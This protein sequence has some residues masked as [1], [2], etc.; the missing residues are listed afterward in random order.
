MKYV[1]SIKMYITLKNT[2]SHDVYVVL[3]N[4]I[5][6]ILHCLFNPEEK[7]WMLRILVID[8]KTNFKISIYIDGIIVAE[9]YD[10]GG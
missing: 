10:T 7:M 3:T 9:K 8:N 2:K 6:I 5:L 4:Y 1:F